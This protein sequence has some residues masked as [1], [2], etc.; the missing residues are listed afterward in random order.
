MRAITRNTT[1][2]S[3]TFEILH[4]YVHIRSE[5]RKVDDVEEIVFMGVAHRK[6][7]NFL[8]R[9]KKIESVT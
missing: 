1:R 6:L 3:S 7:V 4:R 5:I 8:E 2:W 9:M